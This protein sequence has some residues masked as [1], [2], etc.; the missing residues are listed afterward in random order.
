MFNSAGGVTSR[1]LAHWNGAVWS[2]LGPV[3]GGSNPRVEALAV[4]P[5]GDLIA[6]GEF[7]SA[8]GVSARSIARWNGTA[9]SAL[10]TGMTGS[11]YPTVYALAALPSGE[12]VAGGAF[13]R[14]GGWLR[15]RSRVGIPTRR[16]GQLW[17]WG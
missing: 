16:D 8:G 3:T 1:G 7:T 13:N 12:I 9:W 2:G 4:L 10:G 15:I 17:V 6:G 14:A 11:T 5:N